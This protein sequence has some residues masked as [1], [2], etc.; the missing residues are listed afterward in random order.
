MDSAKYQDVPFG[1]TF[2]EVLPTRLF[3]GSNPPGGE[4][5]VLWSDSFDFSNT[6]SHNVT[7]TWDTMSGGNSK[8]E[9]WL[10]GTMMLEKD[11][12]TFWT[13]E[14]Y[15]K[16]GIYIVEKEDHD[17]VGGSNVSDNFVYGAQVSDANLAECGGLGGKNRIRR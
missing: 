1:F 12:L 8:L 9:V 10:N 7:L 11:G 4:P 14:C 6:T 15:S 16:F 13:G 2:T 17:M 5:A 3:A